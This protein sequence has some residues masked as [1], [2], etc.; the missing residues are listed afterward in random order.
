MALVDYFLKV[1]GIKGEAQAEGH[2]E[3]IQI[4]SFSWGETNSGTAAHGGGAGAGKVAMQDLHFVKKIDKSSA[5]LMASC[6]EG[7]H[8]K[9]VELS[10]RKAGGKQEEYLHIKFETVLVSSYQIGGS[11]GSDIVPM[12]QVSLNFAKIKF[13][14]KEQKAEGGLGGAIEAGFDLLKGVKF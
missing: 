7:K 10:C 2:K 1:D 8:L 3:D 13:T 14:Y 9:F 11:A 4:E 5:I 12:E 6:A